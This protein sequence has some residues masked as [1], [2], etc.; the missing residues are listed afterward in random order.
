MI[1][2]K[3]ILDAISEC[4]TE[5]ITSSKVGKLADL[6]IIHNHLFGRTNIIPQ[7]NPRQKTI[8]TPIIKTLCDTEFLAAINGKET[9]CVINILNDLFDALKIL[10]PRIYDI[11]IQKLSNING[12]E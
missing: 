3:E 10:Q 2:E 5:P 12:K 6:Y 7:N 9:Q 1:T 8:E 4:E 11:I